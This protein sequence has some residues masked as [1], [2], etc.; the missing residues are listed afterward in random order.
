MCESLSYIVERDAHFRTRIL[1]SA[2]LWIALGIKDEM[3]AAHNTMVETSRKL[4]NA[5]KSVC[6]VCK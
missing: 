1:G 2:A 4:R 6:S 5:H 3:T